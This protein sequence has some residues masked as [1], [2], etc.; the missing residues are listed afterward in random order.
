MS[1]GMLNTLYLPELREMLAQS[2]ANGLR[3]FCETLHPSRTADFM[4]GLEA[5]EAWQVICSADVDV[6]TQIFSFFDWDR[7]IQILREEDRDEVA[8]VIAQLPAD[9]RV[10]LLSEIDKSIFNE[11]LTRLPLEERR[12]IMRLSQYPEGTAG[13]VMTTDVIGLQVN[14]TVRAALAQLTNEAN[15]SEMVYYLYVVDDENRLKGVVSARELV[16]AMRRPDRPLSEIMKTDLIAVRVM[17]D[18]E[19]VA[20]LVA[21]IDLLAIPVIDEGNKL[22]G[23]ITHDDIIDVV[24][25]EATEDAQQMAAVQPLEDSYM[26]TSVLEL[27]WKRGVWLTILFFCSLFTAI[28][29]QTF[30]SELFPWMIAFIPLV[31]SSGGNSGSQSATL[32]ITAMSRGDV[33]LRDWQHVVAREIMMGMLLGGTLALIGMGTMY[34]FPTMTGLAFTCKLVVPI[35]L[36]LIV[37]SGTLTGSILPLVFNRIGW[38]PAIMS[39]PLV[40]GIMDVLGIVIYVKV[41]AVLLAQSAGMPDAAA[42]P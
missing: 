4:E 25:E 7:Q 18:Q 37:I 38:D 23:I 2:D 15:D 5:S 11:I 28:A 16:S 8:E 41:A 26:R 36:I 35:T 27:S 19:A 9:D 34:L 33:S 39:N 31:I 12:D 1:T 29:L 42:I 32:I 20:D 10:D 6:R 13:A 30:H 14:A 21:K 40:A 22:L 3:I 24:L 17:E